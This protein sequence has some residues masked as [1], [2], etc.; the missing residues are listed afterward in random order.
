MIMS[1]RLSFTRG[2]ALPTVG[3]LWGACFVGTETLS[4]LKEACFAL[5]PSVLASVCLHCL[6]DLN[7][8]LCVRSF[9]AM[10]TATYDLFHGVIDLLKPPRA[11]RARTC[12][13]GDDATSAS[14][15][16]TASTNQATLQPQ[17][18]A[19]AAVGGR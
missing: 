3:A 13:H 12:G 19:G 18:H 8:L 1:V 2:K 7:V 6:L 17:L 4:R 9:A 11:K 16:V 15:S 14:S 5:W 10:D